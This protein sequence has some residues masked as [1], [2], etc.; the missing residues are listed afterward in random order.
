MTTASGRA[1][2]TRTRNASV[3]H[4][5]VPSAPATTIQTTNVH[6]TG[7]PLLLLSRSLVSLKKRHYQAQVVCQGCWRWRVVS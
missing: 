1:S 4:T 7:P 3:R 5:V 6:F 2:G